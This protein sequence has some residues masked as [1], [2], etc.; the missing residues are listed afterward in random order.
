MLQVE[1]IPEKPVK[2]FSEAGGT[3]PPLH[4][5]FP[6]RYEQAYLIEMDLFLDVVTDPSLPCPVTKESV[7]LAGRV[8]DA[9]EKS[10]KEGCVVTL[11]TSS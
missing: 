11:D 8:A 7:L 6:Q 10:L 4:F 9:C 2:S 3:T 1:N 5:S